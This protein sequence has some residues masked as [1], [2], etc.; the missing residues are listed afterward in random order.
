M[1][2]H[3][4]GSVAILTIKDGKVDAKIIQLGG[5]IGGNITSG[6]PGKE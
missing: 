1:Y 6:L 4:I 2:E 5:D 3:T